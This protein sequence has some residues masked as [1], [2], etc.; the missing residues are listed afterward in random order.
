MF[1]LLDIFIE[2]ENIDLILSLR[3]LNKQSKDS[4]DNHPSWISKINEIVFNYKTI[5][6]E[7]ESYLIKYINIKKLDDERRK[8]ISSIY[9]SEYITIIVINSSNKNVNF[10]YNQIFSLK[11]IKYI[12]F[13]HLYKEYFINTISHQVNK[14]Y[15]YFE[16]KFY[17]N[18]KRF[19]HMRFFLTN[20]D[21]VCG[22][23]GLKLSI[24]EFYEI[25]D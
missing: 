20:F 7:N 9:L 19:R 6:N 25:C 15:N 14:F 5:E 8:I 23:E 11:E 24:R 13:F 17:D 4:I 1:E 2:Y 10:K 16:V 21:Y 3:F 12:E 22:S 18:N